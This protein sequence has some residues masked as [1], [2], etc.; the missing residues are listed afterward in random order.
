MAK[1]VRLDHLKGEEVQ[2]VQ[3]ALGVLGVL[4]GRHLGD[5]DDGGE[6]VVGDETNLVVHQSQVAGEE[7]VPVVNVADEDYGRFLPNLYNLNLCDGQ[8]V[9]EEENDD[10][11]MEEEGIQGEE[12]VVEIHEEE[13]EGTQ[14]EVEVEE[15]TQGGDDGGDDDVFFLDLHEVVVT[16]STLQNFL[17]RLIVYPSFLQSIE[18]EY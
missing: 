6:D 16:K 17:K 9:V 10:E 7:E 14:E 12:E 5:D 8:T 18:I 4:E 11:E 15:G 13:E 2:E 3:E 1:L